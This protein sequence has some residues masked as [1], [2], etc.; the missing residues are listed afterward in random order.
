MPNIS[1]L[2]SL[3]CISG[4]HAIKFIFRIPQLDQ[5]CFQLLLSCIDNHKS[6]KMVLVCSFIL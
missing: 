5:V 1:R 4:Y 2:Q 3:L 6:I